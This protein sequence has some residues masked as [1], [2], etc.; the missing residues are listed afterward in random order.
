MGHVERGH[1]AFLLGELSGDGWWYYFPVTFLVKTPLLILV[2]LI[3]SIGVVLSRRKLWKTSIFLGLPV[4]ALFAAAMTSGLNIGYRHILPVLPFFFVFISTS[5]IFFGRWPI[6]R[7][8][9]LLGL[10]WYVISGIRQQP[11][12]LAYFNE[13]A[14]GTGNGFN[15]LGDSNLD[16][17]QDINLL[18]D[19]IRGR[20]GPWYV[21]YAGIG[22]PA[23]YDIPDEVLIDL[24]ADNESFFRANPAPGSYAISANNLQGNIPDADFF[25]WFRRKEP[26]E[27]LGGS[28]LVYEISKMAE[29]AWVAFCLDPGPLLSVDEAEKM[30]GQTGL[31]TITFDCDQSL[32]LPNP[33]LPGWFILPQTEYWWFE[34]ILSVELKMGLQ[35]V[36][37]HRAS[38]DL[39]SFDIYYWPGGDVQ[40]LL[41]QPN[42]S[43]EDVDGSPVRLPFSLSAFLQ[44]DGY[45]TANG[46]WITAW[47]ILSP[48]SQPLSLQAHFY[49]NEAAQ[50]IIADSLG[51]SSDQWQKGDLF[52]NR[53]TIAD[54][55]EP[56]SLETGLYNFQTLDPVG[57]R[58]RLFD[59]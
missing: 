56:R 13:L 23:Y 40:G 34:D 44:L 6:S 42:R 18:A 59:R 28:I 45:R 7:I 52:I 17:G 31:R 20:Q 29:G 47:T 37:R 51:Y 11:N 41:E 1:Q 53:F 50:P 48:T 14:G 27:N 9:L 33:Q 3:L 57:Q 19:E 38:A 55:W 58:L 32:V 43:A 30:I 35:L 22:D 4:I 25:D 8:L 36:Y 24:E 16:W 5:W 54:D 26:I 46:Q 21:S 15:Y 39:P 10:G 2:L 49:E 12:Y